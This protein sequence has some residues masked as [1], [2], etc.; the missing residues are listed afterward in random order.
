MWHIHVIRITI[1]SST[2]L[3]RYNHSEILIWSG[4][5]CSLYWYMSCLMSDPL[6]RDCC[7]TMSISVTGLCLS[8]NDSDH[9]HGVVTSTFNPMMEYL[10]E[11]SD[12]HV[13]LAWWH[14]SCVQLLYTISFINPCLPTLNNVPFSCYCCQCFSCWSLVSF[15]CSICVVLRGC[16]I[17]PCSVSSM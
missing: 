12:V 16:P 2:S 7:A 15:W 17:C 10:L 9:C 13:V 5:S 3:E 11:D 14:V 1:C 4:A 8:D 6:F